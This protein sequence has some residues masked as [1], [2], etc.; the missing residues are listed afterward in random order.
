MMENKKSFLL[1]PLL[2]LLAVAA[3]AF[4]GISAA[5]YADEPSLVF[6]KSEVSTLWK[7]KSGFDISVPS[8][9]MSQ[10]APYA[11]GELAMLAL[12]PQTPCDITVLDPSTAA[13]SLWIRVSEPTRM[14]ADGQIE[15]NS[16]ASVNDANEVRWNVG[17]L[18]IP[19]ANWHKVILPIAAY[20]TGTVNKSAVNFFRFYQKFESGVQGRVSVCDL[21][22]VE[23]AL[24]APAIVASEDYVEKESA[25]SGAAVIN[26][27]QSGKIDVKN[28]PDA[29]LAA[30]ITVA[31]AAVAAAAAAALLFFVY[32]KKNNSAHAD[33]DITK[34]Q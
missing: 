16:S 15:I 19:D 34:N 30:A 7:S 12:R 33:K 20:T 2:V 24:D 11:D 10:K 22:F 5:S 14:L 26:N 8:T 23:S 13:L 6:D 18:G 31:A 3:A 25:S 28:E 27:N 4:S 1:I 17:G 29:L 32:Y 21:V 9:A